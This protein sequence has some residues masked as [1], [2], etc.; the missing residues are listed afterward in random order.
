MSSI[1]VSVCATIRRVTP[2][3]AD[4]LD[5][6]SAWAS[7]GRAPQPQPDDGPIVPD[8]HL[9]AVTKHGCQDQAQAFDV[10][11][12]IDRRAHTLSLRID[13]GEFPS[14]LDASL[15]PVS[16]LERMPAPVC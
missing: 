8:A 6:A 10:A 13:R 9:V 7:N 15:P 1:I 16:W 12:E 11:G 14:D 2:T 3:G 4:E 5:V